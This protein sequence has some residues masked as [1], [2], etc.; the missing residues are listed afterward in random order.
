MEQHGATSREGQTEEQVL[1]QRARKRLPRVV[2][3]ALSCQI[4]RSFWTMLK[5][6]AGI[7]GVSAWSQELDW[8]VLVSPFQFHDSIIQIEITYNRLTLQETLIFSI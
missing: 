7:I 4:T 5:D 1:H 2:V 6:M 8:A 3:T